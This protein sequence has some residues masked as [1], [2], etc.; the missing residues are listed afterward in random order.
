MFFVD[1]KACHELL[2]SITT[3]G[4]WCDPP[5]QRIWK[6]LVG[7]LVKFLSPLPTNKKD[8]MRKPS[9]RIRVI[10]SCRHGIA[11]AVGW[12][13]LGEKNHGSGMKEMRSDTSIS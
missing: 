4:R 7:I 11:I 2:G 13:L 9:R 6:S 1:V 8:K 3:N 10:L 5:S 12:W